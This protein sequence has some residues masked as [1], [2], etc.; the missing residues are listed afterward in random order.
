[1]NIEF[2]KSFDEGFAALPALLR[3]KSRKAIDSFLSSFESRRYPKGLRIHKCGP[4][5][6]LS[7]T[8]KHRIF[9]ASIPKGVRFVFIGDHEDADRYLR[10]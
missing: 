9:V 1:V 10:K 6:S 5:I 4:F 3:E 2:T 8:M 7:V